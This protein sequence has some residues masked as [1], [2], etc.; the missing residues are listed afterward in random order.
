[1]SKIG[2]FVLKF[3]GRNVSASEIILLGLENVERFTANCKPGSQHEQE[4][5]NQTSSYV[6][7]QT[8]GEMTNE[9]LN[10]HKK[11]ISESVILSLYIGGQN[12]MR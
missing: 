12:F 7:R 11:G 6:N 4:K 8:N 10:K 5:T 1:V 3:N 9:D 2:R